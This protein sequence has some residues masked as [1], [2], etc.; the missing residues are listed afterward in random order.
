VSRGDERK[1]GIWYMSVALEAK[2]V[3]ERYIRVAAIVIVTTEGSWNICI[4]KGIR[5][6]SV[7]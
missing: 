7:S 5:T 3:R 6:S 1:V 2:S 4:A